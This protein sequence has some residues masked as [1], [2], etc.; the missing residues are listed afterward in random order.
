MKTSILMKAARRAALFLFASTVAFPQNMFRGDITHSGIYKGQGPKSFEKVKWVFKTDGWV[1]SSPTLTDGVL[2]VGSDDGKLYAID[3]DKGQEKWHFAT[4]GGFAG[5]PIRSTAAIVNGTVYF[6]SYDGFFYALE[7]A[8]G[9]LKWK[10]EHGERQFEAKHLHYRPPVNQTS[11]DF[12]DFFESSAAVDKGVVYFGSG[13]G[14]MYALDAGTGQLKWKFATKDVVHSS[15]A[16]YDGVV[17]FGSW[18][19]RLYA[20]DAATGQEK[21]NY[22]TGLDNDGHNQVG[23]QSSPSV[24]DGVVYFASRHGGNVY[25]LDAKTGKEIWHFDNKGSWISTSPVVYDGLVYVGASDPGIFRALDAKSGELKYKLDAKMFIFSS[26]SIAGGMA[27]FGSLN[28]KLYAVD[29]KSRQFAWEFQT[30][31]G[32]KDPLG[33]TLPDGR[34]DEYAIWKEIAHGRMLEAMY[35]S[36]ERIFSLGSIVS[37]PAIEGGVIFFGSTDGNVYA[38]E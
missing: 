21:W 8:T 35:L 26:A 28:G 24:V 9:K 31:A 22:M 11:A 18:D 34:P 19:G 27:Y 29:L 16:I 25:A 7:A 5:G 37:S 6:S 14:N 32:K 30:A 38:I 1:I 10:F 2:Y 33:I 12:W 3:A 36:S 23:I 20:V 4:T 17:Y 13:D 15:P